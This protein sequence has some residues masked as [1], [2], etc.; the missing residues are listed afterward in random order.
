MFQ[1]RRNNSSPEQGEGSTEGLIQG[2]VGGHFD[3]SKSLDVLLAAR[4]NQR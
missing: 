2:S 1:D 4:K 3:I